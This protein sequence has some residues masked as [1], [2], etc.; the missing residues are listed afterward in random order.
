M[1]FG[2]VDGAKSKA[3]LKTGVSLFIQFLKDTLILKKS[4]MK[5]SKNSILKH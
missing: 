1:E 3:L 4:M 5:P 2:T